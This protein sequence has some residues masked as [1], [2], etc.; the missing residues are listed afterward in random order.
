MSNVT[1]GPTGGS[2]H[3]DGSDSSAGEQDCL[4]KS[5]AFWA[6]IEEVTKEALLEMGYVNGISAGNPT[7]V[8]MCAGAPLNFVE[9]YQLMAEIVA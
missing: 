5:N 8:S 3:I 9:L 1:L 4:A 2:N 7:A 6:D